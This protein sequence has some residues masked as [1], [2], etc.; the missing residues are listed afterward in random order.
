MDLEEELQRQAAAHRAELETLREEHRKACKRAKL[1]MLAQLAPSKA[2]AQEALAC[3]RAEQQMLKGS[4]SAP[5]FH[6]GCAA[7]P[8]GHADPRWYQMCQSQPWA[9]QPAQFAQQPCEAW[10]VP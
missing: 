10:S 2:A 5:N 3:D 4:A 1:H 7:A 6:P 9:Q 8:P